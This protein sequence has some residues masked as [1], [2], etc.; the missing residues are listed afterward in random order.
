MFRKKRGKIGKK[1]GPAVHEDLCATTDEQGLCKVL[2]MIGQLGEELTIRTWRQARDGRS[3]RQSISLYPSIRR[4]FISLSISVPTGVSVPMLTHQEG[5]TVRLA[6]SSPVPPAAD[7]E[8]LFQCSPSTN[9]AVAFGVLTAGKVD[10]AKSS[11]GA[12]LAARVASTIAEKPSM[13][14]ATRSL[15]LRP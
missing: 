7:I 4:D 9:H 13:A 8:L 10:S 12:G 5:S 11:N 15:D 6:P 1:P 14:R 2:S 3:A